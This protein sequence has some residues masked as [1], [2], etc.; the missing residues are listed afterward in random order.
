MR[1]NPSKR[2]VSQRVRNRVVECLE[3]S[4]D[5]DA[6]M[7]YEQIVYVPY[8]LVNSWDDWVHSDPQTDSHIDP[9]YYQAEIRAMGK[10]HAVLQRAASALTRDYPPIEQ[11]Q[12]MP[13]WNELRDVAIE[14]LVVFAE[15]GPMSEEFEEL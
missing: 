10:Y 13:E 7:A 2:V 9:V 14:A 5:F 15:R 1:D 4:A 12:L 11:V 8:E 6:Q 3:L